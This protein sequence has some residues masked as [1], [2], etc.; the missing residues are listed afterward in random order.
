MNVLYSIMISFSFTKLDNTIFSPNGFFGSFFSCIRTCF[1]TVKSLLGLP[2]FDYFV[3][4]Q[5]RLKDFAFFTG[6]PVNKHNNCHRIGLIGS[7][8]SQRP[9]LFVCR[10]VG[11]SV[12]YL[13]KVSHQPSYRSNCFCLRIS[14][15]VVV[16]DF[17][18]K[19]GFQYMASSFDLFLPTN[20]YCIKET[21]FSYIK[22]ILIYQFY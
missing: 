17:I 13:R 20:V 18:L 4:R 22:C 7:E 1:V 11:L 5:G 15:Y 12:L 3:G 16:R 10:S 14:Y 2:A 19:K 8:T 9:G 6:V 21:C